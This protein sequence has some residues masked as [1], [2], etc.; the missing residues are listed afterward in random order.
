MIVAHLSLC[1]HYKVIFDGGGL[2]GGRSAA[3]PAETCLIGRESNCQNRQPSKT[4][5]QGRSAGTACSAAAVV[6]HFLGDTGA[7]VAI[8]LGSCSQY[9]YQRISSKRMG[10]AKR[11]AEMVTIQSSR[12]D[13][14]GLLTHR[15]SPRA[16][17][18]KPATTFMM[19]ITWNGTTRIRVTTSTLTTIQALSRTNA[20]AV[21]SCPSLAF[22]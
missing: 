10:T 15:L 6:V 4:H 21:N 12:A 9:A 5:R 3:V 2:T 20:I 18:P 11:R 19:I 14:P 17:I 8:T 13:L 7:V 22:I 16:A 1:T